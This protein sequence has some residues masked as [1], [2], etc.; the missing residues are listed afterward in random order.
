[1]PNSPEVNLK[2]IEE[3]AKEIIESNSGKN[4]IFE[5]EPIAFGLKAIIIGF[6]INETSGEIDPIE[7]ALQKIEN[8]NSVQIIDMRRALE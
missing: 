6:G 7:E 2:E 1:M 5:E 4:I 8:V 3:Q